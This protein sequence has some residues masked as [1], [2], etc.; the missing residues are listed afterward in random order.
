MNAYFTEP[1]DLYRKVRQLNNIKWGSNL[2]SSF[3]FI[4][5]IS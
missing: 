1:F 3:Q 4:F 5:S 2:T